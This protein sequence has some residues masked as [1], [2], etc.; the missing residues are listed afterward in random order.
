MFAAL[1]FVDSPLLMS[2]EVLDFPGY[3]NTEE[4]SQKVEFA[5]GK[6]IIDI[7]V[8]A[9][10]SLAFMDVSDR[11]YL[12][13]LLR[14]LPPI[15]SEGVPH[16][17]NAFVVATRAAIV[18]DTSE[19]VG[20]LD[21]AGKRSYEF[22][23]ESLRNISEGGVPQDAFRSRF[24]T[25]D[26]ERSE[27]RKDFESDL[28][29]LLGRVYPSLQRRRVDRAIAGARKRGLEQLVAE[30]GRIDVLL[31]DAA[32]MAKELKK[33]EDWEPHRKVE[34]ENKAENVRR[35]IAKFKKDTS[36]FIRNTLA[37]QCSAREIENLIRH[38]RWKKKEAQEECGPYLVNNLQDRLD[39]F[40]TDK[41]ERL[42]DSIE[43]V[44][45]TYRRSDDDLSVYFMFDSR[46]AFIA[47]LGGLA[48]YGALS[49]W[50]AAV[51]AGSNLR[52]YILIAKVVSVLS[53]MG[54]ALGGTG[55]V[56]SA[57]GALGGPVT[58]LISLAM[59]AA[60][61]LWSIFGRSW[62]EQ[63]AKRLAQKF[64]EDNSIQKID[65]AAKSYWDDTKKAFDTGFAKTEEA[66]REKLKKF[67]REVDD[68]D[69]DALREQQEYIGLLRN[70]L[71][72]LPWRKDSGVDL[73]L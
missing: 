65:E 73:S 58:L 29:E 68:K 18:D 32:S 46:A 15:G 42:S 62:E 66:Y 55:A 22:M 38:K 59:F 25:F 17:R 19:R 7:L 63:L 70:R 21:K 1:M 16:L 48:T 2:C 20:I 50:A 12:R 8:Y 26:A 35:T 14:K 51:A 3:S 39:R 33:L 69:E 43:D 52:G 34:R 37:P 44:H 28:K 49:S 27:F 53:R 10:A 47:G 6:G 45:E 31:S 56:A 71:E 30:S 23:E 64:K 40:V 9:S 54:I 41:A 24:F 13:N 60:S 61:V 5:K 57:V 4:D 67:R 36:A 72:M 11:V